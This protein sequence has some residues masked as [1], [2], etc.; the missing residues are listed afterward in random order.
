MQPN[1]SNP[2]NRPDRPNWKGARYKRI[3]TDTQ[4]RDHW[5]QADDRIVTVVSADG[6]RLVER[7]D[8]AELGKNT[9]HWIDYVAERTGWSDQPLTVLSTAALLK[10]TRG[11]A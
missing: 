7:Y 10:A 5:L 6:T 2:E 1:A 9:Q 11:G 3:G 8:L 4:N